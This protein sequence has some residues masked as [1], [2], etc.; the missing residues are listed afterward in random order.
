MNINDLITQTSENDVNEDRV[1]LMNYLKD[2]FNLTEFDQQGIQARNN[3]VSRRFSALA[4]DDNLYSNESYDLRES[5]LKGTTNCPEKESGCDYFHICNT[6][7]HVDFPSQYKSG[8]SD[9]SK[10]DETPR[11]SHYEPMSGAE[12]ASLE[13]FSMFVE[14]NMSCNVFDKCVKMMN[15]YMTE[16]RLS[17]KLTTILAVINSLMSYYKMDT[18]LRQE[19]TVRPVTHD[20]CKKGCTRFEAI[21]AGQH[22]D[23]EEWCPH[24]NSQQFQCD[25]GTL[26]PVQTFQVVPLSE[27]LRFKLGNAQKRTKMEY[28][29][30]RLSHN[31]STTRSNILDSNAV[32]RLVQSGVVSQNDILVTMF[33]EQFN[34]FNDSKMS[35]TVVHLNMLRYKRDNMMQLAIIPGPE[36]PK[37]ITSF[38]ETIVEDLHMLQTSGLRVQTNSGQRY[39]VNGP[40]VFRD[41]DTLTSPAFFGLDEMHLIGHEIGH[42]LYKALGGKF[43]LDQINRLISESRAN[44]PVI[45]TG[46]WRSLKEM[47]GRQKAVNWLDFLLFVVPAVVIKNFVLVSTRNAVQDLVDACTIAQ[48]WEVTEAEICNMEDHWALTFLPSERNCRRKD[49]TYNFRDEPAHAGSSRVLERNRKNMKNIL[50]SKAGIRH[51]LSGEVVTREPRNRRTSNFEAASNNVAGP[52]LWSNPTRKTLVAVASETDINYYTLVCF[53]ADLWGQNV[54]S[55]VEETN[56]VVCTSKMWKDQVVYRVQASFD[57]RHV[58]A[59]DLVVLKHPWGKLYGFV[60]KFFSYSVLG[61]T[62]LYTIVDHLCGIQPNNE[63]MFPV[64]ESTTISDKKVVDVKSIKGMAGLVHDVNDKTVRYV[65]EVS[66]SH[67]Q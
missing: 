36:H 42:Q 59:T 52:Q 9:E 58:Q 24:C 10:L 18:L 13:L 47:T 44:I 8:K 14:N 66:Q 41:L 2:V 15:K 26:I 12:A 25:R 60:C 63:G 3:H 35:A 22:A 67:Y 45:F 5:M 39:S 62:R 56:W 34:P 54:V 57:S 50:F 32:R 4:Y 31:V 53:L 61:E 7:D 19:Y 1:E 43:A 28:G 49:E 46:S 17:C 6:V 51:C 65:V 55:M 29:K 23:E 27:Q 20:M 40:N 11:V 16:C 21:E 48:K 33:V 64:W 37:N 38:L 30:N